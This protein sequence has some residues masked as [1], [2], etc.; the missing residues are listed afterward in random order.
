MVEKALTDEEPAG[1]PI[2]ATGEC[3]ALVPLVNVTPRQ[4][5][6]VSRPAAFLA[7][8][9]AVKE[10]HPQTRERRRAEPA[11]AIRAYLGTMAAT[12]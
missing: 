4:A 11:Y 10:Q 12:S 6:A 3:R 9:I 1:E 2:P 5:C 8:L 7:H